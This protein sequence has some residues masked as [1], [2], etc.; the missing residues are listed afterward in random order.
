VSTGA[1]R[2]LLAWLPAVAYMALIWVLSSMPVQVDLEEVPFHDKGVHF[3]EYGV[4][5]LLLGHAL[6]G[7]W[8][9]LGPV[10][11][12]LSAFALSTLWGYLDE[13][14]QAFVPGRDSSLMDLLADALGSTLGACAFFLFDKL[15]K[16]RSRSG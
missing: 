14:H 11:V 10:K 6:R 2:A 1:R 3:V 12:V 16:R 15:R 4:L 8:P 9:P 7:N 5:A 13:L